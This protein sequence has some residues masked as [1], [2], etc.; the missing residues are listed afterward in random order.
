MKPLHLLVISVAA[1]CGGPGNAPQAGVPQGPVTD[2]LGISSALAE[3]G[4]SLVRLLAT[5]EDGFV[6][7]AAERDDQVF[8]LVLRKAGDRYL[9]LGAERMFEDVAPS[10]AEW[11]V[12]PSGERIVSYMHQFPTAGLVGTIIR[13]VEGDSLRPVFLE[14]G[15]VC[16]PSRVRDVDGDGVPEIEAYS[17]SLAGT[18]CTHRCSF[19]LEERFP[20]G[21]H[22]VTL[23][24]IRDATDVSGAHP[25]YY[26]DLAE[27]YSE[28]LAWMGSDEADA[29]GCGP[30]DAPWLRSTRGTLSEWISRARALER[31]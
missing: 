8:F 27:Y 24:S 21:G 6:A 18:D 17:E 13:R 20:H 31:G 3:D 14:P 5:T 11:I 1:A 22:W 10:R 12:L 25:G 26:G 15:E 19:E 4:S 23:R 2:T 30:T 29:R 9:R 28:V 7:L 16:R